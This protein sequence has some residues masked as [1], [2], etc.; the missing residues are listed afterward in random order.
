MPLN[1]IEMKTDPQNL[2]EFFPFFLGDITKG[3]LDMVAVRKAAAWNEAR[4]LGL[5]LAALGEPLEVVGV[6]D[7]PRGDR[8]ARD[9]GEGAVTACTEHLVASIYF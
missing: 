2:K 8:L 6:V 5:M 9:P 3:R 7:G 1:I 4:M